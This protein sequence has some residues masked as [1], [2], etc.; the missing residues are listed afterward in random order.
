M[1]LRNAWYVGAISGEVTR[2]PLGRLIC[3]EPVVLYRTEGGAAVALEDRCPHRRAPLHKGTVVGETLQ[4]GYHGFR[5]DGGGR[6]VA[7]PGSEVRPPAT[8]R[9]RSY[10]AVERHNYVWVWT[11]DPRRA[12]A[13]LIPDLHSNADPAWA[14]AYERMHVAAD[15]GLFVDNLLDLSHVAF[16]HRNTIGSDD[17]HAELRLE[18]SD[19]TVRLVREAR[20]IPT[21]PLYLKQ[22]FGPT[23]HQTKVI[24]FVPPALVT[25]EITTTEASSG[26]EAARALLS[27]HIF[28]VNV[29][30]PETERTMHYFWASN[31]D[32]DVDNAE[33]TAFFRR[34]THRAFLED[35]DIIEAQQRCIDLDPSRSDVMVAVDVGSIQARK[36]MARLL[37]RETLQPV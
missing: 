19:E 29:M 8:A 9:V 32:F 13:A 4:C 28:L 17:S 7:I 25:I 31:R 14:S 22:G 11:G 20:D 3:G 37:E 18:T 15:Y 12:D 23:A 5:F 16:V 2:A 33:L 36:L 6:C 26:G 34:E 24:T 27:K 21:P 10:P 35:V 1:Y 30:T